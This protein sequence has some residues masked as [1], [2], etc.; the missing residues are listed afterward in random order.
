MR[1]AT[2]QKMLAKLIVVAAPEEFEA[3]LA[4]LGAPLDV[5]EPLGAG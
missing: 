5:K 1:E 3:N 2:L 4:L